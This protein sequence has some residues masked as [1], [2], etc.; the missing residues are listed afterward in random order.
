MLR[1]ELLCFDQQR[2]ALGIAPAVTPG[3]PYF[4]R[5]VTGQRREPARDGAFGQASRRVA[6]ASEIVEGA[7]QPPVVRRQVSRLCPRLH[8]LLLFSSLLEN[9]LQA[10]SL[11]C[12]CRMMRVTCVCLRELAERMCGFSPCLLCFRERI[13]DLRI[14]HG[15]DF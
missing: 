15:D 10:L 11:C 2:P 4:E 6:P 8:H 12:H 7:Y 5:P 3:L 9:P 13:G 1:G 14:A